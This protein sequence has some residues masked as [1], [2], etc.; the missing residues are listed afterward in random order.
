MKDCKYWRCEW[1]PLRHKFNFFQ[2]YKLSFPWKRESRVR[3]NYL[4][5]KNKKFNQLVIYQAKN[6]AIEFRGDFERDTVWGNLNQIAQLFG[7]VNRL[8]LA[9]L[10]TFTKPVN[11]TNRQLL[12][13]LQRFRKGNLEQKSCHSR[14]PIR[15]RISFAGM[16]NEVCFDF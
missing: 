1:L 6:G 2:F 11:W 9:M 12:Q 13:K 15:S 5:M 7:R 16:T 14:S 8:Y 3:F 4:I 10:I